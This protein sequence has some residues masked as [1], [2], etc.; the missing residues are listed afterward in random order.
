MVSVPL[1]D[2]ADIEIGAIGPG[3]AGAIH[4]RGAGRAGITADKAVAIAHRAA[5]ADGQRAVAV[6]ADI[7]IGAVGPGRAGA[8]HRRGPGRAGIVGDNTQGVVHRAAVLDRQR[9]G[10]GNADP[11]TGRL[12]AGRSDHRR[13]GRDCVDPRAGRVV[14]N[15]GRPVADAEPV[16]RG[17]AVPKFD[18]ARRCRRQDHSKRD[19]GCCPEAP[20]PPDRKTRHAP[21][22]QLICR[23]TDAN[24]ICSNEPLTNKPAIRPAAR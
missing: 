22:L 8:I 7:E 15:D 12:R 4:R 18:G 21:P 17:G 5:V 2:S 16:G 3:R 1:P 23:S 6:M 10:A 24:T 19:D 20:P 13:V 11:E 9:A 14:W